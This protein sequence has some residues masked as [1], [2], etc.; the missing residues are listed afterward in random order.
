MSQMN[1]SETSFIQ[2]SVF[3]AFAKI[4]FVFC[5]SQTWLEIVPNSNCLEQFP[6]VF[7]PEM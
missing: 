4:K 3:D 1:A 7:V 5:F 6:A 2:V